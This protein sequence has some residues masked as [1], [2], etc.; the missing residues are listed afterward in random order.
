LAQRTGLS[1][2][3]PSRLEGG[4]R[5]PSLGALL[6]SAKA[7]GVPFSSLFGSEAEDLAVVRAS[8]GVA[9]RGNGLSYTR[10]SED[11]WSFNLQPLRLVVP[12]DREGDAV[13]RHE[14]EQWTHVLSGR[15]RFGIGDWE[16]MDGR[17]AEAIVVACAVPY[18]L[19][20]SYL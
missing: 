13:Y 12:A 4:E 3:Y 18:L 2:A 19:L 11:G 17:D 7:Y 16:A 15:L 10:L 14:G 8:E 9:Q 6:G 20:R 1:K 5:Q